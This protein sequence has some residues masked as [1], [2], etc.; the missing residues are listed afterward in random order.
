VPGTIARLALVF[1]VFLST[2]AGVLA[3]SAA[4][5]IAGVVRDTTGAVLPGVTVEAASPALIEKVRSVVTDTQGNYK[6]TELRPG[7]YSVTF[8]VPGFSTVKREGVELTTGFTATVNAELTVGSLEETVT[9]TGASPVVDVQNV[10]T[11]TVLKREVLDQTPTAQ[12]LTGFAALTVGLK[13]TGSS[14]Q[15][16]DVGGSI[17]EGTVSLVIH[18]GRETDTHMNFDG[19]SA[20]NFVTSGGGQGRHL[21]IN[22]A[23]AEEVTL[24]TAA[25]SAENETGGIEVN[26]IPK[27]GGNLF[28]G[29]FNADWTNKD[30]QS[31]NLNDA[32]RARGV[33]RQA[34]LNYQYDLSGA[35]GGPL[36]KDRVWFYNAYRKQ[37]SWIYI[38]GNFYNLT[39][40]TLFFTPGRISTV[41]R[42]GAARPRM[43]A[44]G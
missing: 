22:R 25:L 4:G 44:C 7:T 24:Q 14:A 31:S 20:G 1:S 43:S 19:L 21:Y 16:P 2:A 18:G 30:L 32:L 26:A 5:G 40:N 23:Y 8:T 9:V 35:I 36:W 15:S 39:P 37:E 3:Q 41:R 11:Q 33:D 6:V 34:G 12:N 10:V 42:N 38:P 27:E 28:T 13:A 17:G 29:V